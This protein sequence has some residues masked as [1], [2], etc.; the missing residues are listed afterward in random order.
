MNVFFEETYAFWL[1]CDA[2]KGTLIYKPV[3]NLQVTE[4]C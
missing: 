3:T 1:H 4:Q 2:V